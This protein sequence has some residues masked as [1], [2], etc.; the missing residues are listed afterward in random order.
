MSLS[1]VLELARG[2]A[3]TGTHIWIQ[4]S[5]LFPLYLTVVRNEF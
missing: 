2:R 1:K 5:M 3:G 4:G